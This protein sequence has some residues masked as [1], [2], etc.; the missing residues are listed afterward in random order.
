MITLSLK[1][2]LP[3]ELNYVTSSGGTFNSGTGLVT[4]PSFNL[5]NA[6]SNTGDNQDGM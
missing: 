5:A 6:Q 3:S 2:T 1:T 4:F